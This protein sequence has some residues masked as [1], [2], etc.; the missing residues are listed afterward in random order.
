M[1]K[2]TLT[3]LFLLISS[4]IFAQGSIKGTVKDAETGKAISEVH[5]TLD[6][7]SNGFTT[8]KEGKY[9][10]AELTRGKHTLIFTHI[11][12][13]ARELKIT[14]KESETKNI[15]ILLTPA[16]YLS[17]EVVVT[18]TRNRSRKDEIPG[19]IRVISRNEISRTPSEKIDDI[20]QYATGVNVLR[21]SGIYSMRPVVSLRGLSGDEQGR[22]LVLVDGVPINKGDTG[23][24]NWNRIDKNS[25]ERIEIFRGPGSSLY[26]N[27]AMGGVINII[28]RNPRRKIQGHAGMSF[29]TYNTQKA[30][31]SFGSKVSKKF[32]Y[33]A[34]AFMVNSEGY[35]AIPENMRGNPDYT[36]PRFLNEKSISGKFGIPWSKAVNLEFQYDYFE[37]MRGEGE[38]IKAPRGEY[39]HFNTNFFRAKAK[40]DLQLFE[41]DLNTWYQKENYFKL[42]ERE[43]NGNYSRFDVNS[44]R[45]DLGFILHVKT[46]LGKHQTLAV[47]LESRQSSVDGGDYYQTS[48]DTVANS[49]KMRFSAVYLQDKI[50][51]LSGKLNLIAGIRFD[52]AKFYDG[53]FYSTDNSWTGVLPELESHTWEAYS[54]RLSASYKIA[55]ESK[56]YL[57]YSQ[58][59]RASILDDLCRSGWMWI[60]PK[61]A[62]PNLGPEKIEN[63]EAGTDVRITESLSFAASLFY[64]KGHDFLYY[65]RTGD[66]LWGSR[67]IYQRQNVTEIEIYGAELETEYNI[68]K[69][70]SLFGFYTFNDSKILSFSKNPA[71]EGKNLKFSPV[72]QVKAGVFWSNSILNTSVNMIYKSKQYIDDLNESEIKPFVSLD[73]KLS[74]DMDEHFNMFLRIQNLFDEQHMDNEIYLSPGRMITLGINV[75]F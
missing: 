18:A 49:G 74:R 29:G 39:R 60:G 58:G 13:Q 64:S 15:D 28:T 6:N 23:G 36:I 31:A 52:H 50:S 41:Y 16:V 61:I 66:S 69:N 72:H 7:K 63:Y 55:N 65:V 3:S 45:I 14:L 1:I 44:D 8:N 12:Y 27:N 42:D 75:L 47:G 57:S 33:S 70:F 48:A 54:P 68:N 11:A 2:T 26:G 46:N 19:N 17:D 73:V 59:F 43:R 56:V 35:N 34:S 25:I 32:W 38:K 51:L 53:S 21:S 9:N 71:L 20:I 37:D 40:G 67:P 10:I 22:T 5:I 30:N 24:V 4:L 62:N